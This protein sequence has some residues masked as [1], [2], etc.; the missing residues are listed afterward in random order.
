[1]ERALD[2]QVPGICQI[3]MTIPPFSLFNGGE[4]AEC[5]ASD[6]FRVSASS[7][8]ATGGRIARCEQADNHIFLVSTV[9]DAMPNKEAVFLLTGI[10]YL[11]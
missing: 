7:G 9:A 1:M 5:L 6:I 10:V 11:S 8:A 2:E 3:V 4:I